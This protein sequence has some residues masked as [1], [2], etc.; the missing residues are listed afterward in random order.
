MIDT[1]RIYEYNFHHPQKNF[2]GGKKRPSPETVFAEKFARSYSE[3]F[4]HIH[5]GTCKDNTLFIREV[6]VSG[7]G[8]ADLVVFSWDRSL[9]RQAS[10][11]LN[12]EE[13]D[14][15]VRAFELKLS[16]WRKGIM[17]A[18]RYKY[19]SHASIL[20]LPKNRVQSVQSELDLF[21]KLGV[22]LWGF[23]LETGSITCFYTPRPR[24]QHIP[25]QVQKAIRLAAQTVCS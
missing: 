5:S 6:P 22:G 10:T 3:R 2:S 12:L 24:Q 18:H 13:L 1:P 9:A 19:F 11:S 21:R 23:A 15:T 20:V 4:L 25:K 17:Q 8:I 16:N 14:P 7:N